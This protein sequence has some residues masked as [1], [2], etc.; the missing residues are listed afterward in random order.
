MDTSNQ[1]I[2]KEFK[3][4]TTTTNYDE[5][6]PKDKILFSIRD[7]DEIG[8]IRSD[9]LKKIIYQRAI[10]VVKLGKKNFISRKILIDFLVNQTMPAEV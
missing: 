10:E 5:L 7:I 1:K 6:L 8:L 9:M 4:E 2:T 3:M